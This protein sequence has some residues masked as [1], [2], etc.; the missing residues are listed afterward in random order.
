VTKAESFA[1]A[2][3]QFESDWWPYDVLRDVRDAWPRRSYRRLEVA[4]AAVR[5]PWVAVDAW[6]RLPSRSPAVIRALLSA[7]CLEALQEI[8]RRMAGTPR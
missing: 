1:A 4:A 8:A 6:T 3:E 7:S 5:N 2:R